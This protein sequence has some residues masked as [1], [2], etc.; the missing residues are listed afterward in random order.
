MVRH[1]I[2]TI[3]NIY[4]VDVLC[5]ALG[6]VVLLWQVSY[7]EA[8]QQTEAATARGDALQASLDQLKSAQLS[9]KSL[10]S[11]VD[12]LKIA[13]DATKKKEVQVTLMLEDT[14]KERDAAEQALMGYRDQ[15]LKKGFQVMF[16][17]GADA[18]AGMGYES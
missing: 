3:F 7:Q 6:C 10:S 13:L 16:A 4:M 14:R 8:E 9:L 12:N 5:C 2:P 17:Q 15:Q 18:P 11:D 1:R